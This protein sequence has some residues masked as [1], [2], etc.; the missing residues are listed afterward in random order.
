MRGDNALAE[1]HPLFSKLKRKSAASGITAGA[2]RASGG[3]L[4]WSEVSGVEG[5]FL[6]EEDG[7]GVVGKRGNLPR[8]EGELV[9]GRLHGG[10]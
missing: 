8:D 10:G 4:R 9:G 5:R 1:N 6:T 7:G 2:G 3:C